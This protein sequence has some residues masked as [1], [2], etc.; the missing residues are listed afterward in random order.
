MNFKD[1]FS[2]RQISCLGSNPASTTDQLVTP[3]VRDCTWVSPNPQH[4]LDSAEVL[5]KSWCARRSPGEDPE[6]RPG[7]LLSRADAGPAPTAGPQPRAKPSCSP[8]RRAGLEEH[9][10]ARKGGSWEA[11]HRGAHG[12]P[13]CSSRAPSPRPGAHLST[14]LS[15][16]RPW[17]ESSPA[18][19]WRVLKQSRCQTR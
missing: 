7:E 10:Y 5:R 13:S 18:L 15:E 17:F 2:V 9:R 12:G 14:R 3:K 6:R 8:D 1:S 11:R 16:Q 19:L 4:A